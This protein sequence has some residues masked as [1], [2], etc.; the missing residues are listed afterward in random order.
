MFPYESRGV[1]RWYKERLFG[2]CTESGLGCY[3]AWEALD[4]ATGLSRNSLQ[5]L[6]MHTG[7]VTQQ[8]S[9]PI[10]DRPAAGQ[11]S[12]VAGQCW[13]KLQLLP[14]LYEWQTLANTGL[15]CALAYHVIVISKMHIIEKVCMNISFF[16]HQNK[17]ISLFCVPKN[18][19]KP[20]YVWLCRSHSV[21][22]CRDLTE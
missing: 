6:C 1:F 13:K 10:S 8:G 16:H 22:S 4:N 9:F 20:S 11:G 21:P 15:I 3:K 7:A 12:M 18:F 17:F 19:L 14:Y 5:P 2:K